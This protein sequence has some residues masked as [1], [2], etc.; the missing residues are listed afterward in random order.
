MKCLNCNK[1]ISDKAKYCNDKCRMA[2]NRK[3]NKQPEQIQPEQAKQPE[4]KQ[5]EQLNP[6][7]DKL[8]RIKTYKV[9]SKGWNGEDMVYCSKHQ[10][11]IKSY[12]LDMCDDCTHILKD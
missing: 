2:F 6:N 3:A 11:H 4:Q 9:F 12:C 8:K 1:V 7:K 10:E 5:P